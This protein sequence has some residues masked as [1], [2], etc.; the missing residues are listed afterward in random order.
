MSNNIRELWWKRLQDSLPPEES[1]IERNRAI[2]AQYAQWY[3]ASPE[4]L[5]WA[6]VAAFASHRVGFSL[7]PYKLIIKDGKAISVADTLDDS[8]DQLV[9]LR[10]LD[11]IRQTNN[12]V[13]ADIG[14]AHLAYLSPGGG[15]EV[16]EAA[17]AQDDAVA[18]AL[19]EG[20]RE[21]EMGRQLLTS[22]DTSRSLADAHIWKGNFLL[23]RHEQ[24][25]TVQRQFDQLEK[26]FTIFL[27][28]VTTTD[29]DANNLT[30]D[31][32]THTSFYKYMWT[33]GLFMLARTRSWPDIT[34]VHHRWHW[35][36][37]R[38][39]PLWRRVDSTDRTLRR[40]MNRMIRQAA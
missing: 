38:V 19:V 36:S 37:R 33:Q 28:L 5:K 10:D 9:L 18:P 29:F 3:L 24:F 14:W 35:I 22:S 2:T 30:M 12:L 27:S 1:V 40:K 13:F 11:L 7:L 34:N 16:I 21:I 23:L 4:L 15:I 31:W 25:V 8:V 26:G 39:F 17:A 32:R 20:F 6:G